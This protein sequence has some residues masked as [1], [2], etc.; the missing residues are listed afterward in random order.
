MKRKEALSLLFSVGTTA[1]VAFIGTLVT[2]PQITSWYLTLKKPVFTPPNWVFGPVWT[3]LYVLMAIA[4]FLVLQTKTKK[5]L[6]MWAIRIYLFQLFLNAL[7]S[8]VFFARH[9]LSGGVVVI[10]LLWLS[11]IATLVLFWRIKPI[12]GIL[13]IAYQAWL[14]LAAALTLGVL[15]LNP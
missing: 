4:F 8:I 6:R 10:V 7:W 14:C 11:A 2:L 9:S 5:G 15:F 3:I 12:A 13:L 1:V